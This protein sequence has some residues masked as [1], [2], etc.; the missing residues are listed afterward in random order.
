[1]FWLRQALTYSDTLQL[2]DDHT[3]EYLSRAYHSLQAL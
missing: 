2:G 3:S 1:M